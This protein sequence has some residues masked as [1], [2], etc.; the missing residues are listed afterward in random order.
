MPDGDWY[1]L[2]GGRLVE[3]E[4][5]FRSSRIGGELNRRLGNHAR[6]QRLGWVV[7]EAGYE[8]FP[9]DPNKVCKPDASFVSF[10]RLPPDREPTGYCKVAPDLAAEVVSPNDGF[11]DVEKKVAGYL[12]AGVRLVWV[13]VPATQVVHIYRADGTCA[14]RRAGD[15]LSG[16]DVVPGFACRVGDLFA[17]PSWP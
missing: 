3:T 16:E 15:E 11:E 7:P 6:E 10:Q 2:V 5:G 13:L 8:C 4:M 14:I 12:E 1:E 17:P 9:D